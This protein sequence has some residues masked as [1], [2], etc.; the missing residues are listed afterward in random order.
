M[1]STS[2]A[3]SSPGFVAQRE[4]E[5]RLA[6]V[7]PKDTTRGFL[8]SAALELVRSQAD[9]EGLKRCVEAAGNSNFTAF[10]SYPVTTLLKLSYA[11]SRELSGKYGG[12]DGAMQQLG[13]RAAPRFLESTTGKMLLSLVGKEPKRLIDSMPTAYK[14]AWDHGS[15]SLTWNG[16]KSGRLAYTNVIPV[17]YFAGSVLQILSAAQLKGQ[18]IGKQLSLTES[19]VDFSWE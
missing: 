18:A 12:F 4:L 16:P 19:T 9:A 1:N 15:C 17:Q 5:Q 6:V 8:F 3:Q 10:F 7:G 13:F 2:T 11:A 14:T